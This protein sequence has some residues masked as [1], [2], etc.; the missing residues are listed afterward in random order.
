MQELE[1]KILDLDQIEK[2]TIKLF[3]GLFF[4]VL[5]SMSSFTMLLRNFG[6][7]ISLLSYIVICAY[8]LFAYPYLLFHFAKCPYCK[9][10]YFHPFLMTKNEMKRILQNS[11]SCI[12]CSKHAQVI[13]RY[14]R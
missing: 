1:K 6:I 14:L 9:S 2:K 8:I 3:F 10:H 7:N 12:K 13:S 11:S 5:I 4:I